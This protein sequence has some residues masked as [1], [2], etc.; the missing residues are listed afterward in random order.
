MLRPDNETGKVQTI[1]S[2]EVFGIIRSLQPF[3][4]VGSKRD[5]IVVGSDSGKIVILQ[6]DGEK[7]VFK[8]IH[9][10]TFGRSGCRRI[11]PGEY[12][13]VDPKGRAIMIGAVEK[14]KFVYVL[15]RDKD[16]NLVI[17]SPLEA[18]KANTVVHS[19]VG[20]DVGFESPIFAAIEIDY[21]EVAQEEKD[22]EMK[23]DHAARRYTKYLTYYEL[24]LGLNHV[25]RKWAEEIDPTSNSLISVP[26][27]DEGP[28]G[29]IICAENCVMYKNQDHAF[30]RAPLPRRLGYLQ[31]SLMIVST[32]T[33]KQKGMFFFLAQSEVGDLYKITLTYDQDE[34]QNVHIRYFDTTPTAL[35]MVILKTGFLFCASEFGNHYLMQFKNIEGNELIETSSL[36]V[37]DVCFKPDP[38]TNL[39]LIDEMESVCPVLDMKV[40][41]LVNEGSPQIYAACG[42]GSRS[43]LRILRHGLSIS[44]A[45]ETEL[46][47]VPNAIWA[48]KR[49]AS[50]P[51]HDYI[52][53]SFV[54][55]TLVLR[56][57]D[58]VEEINDS[59]VQADTQTLSMST[60]GEDSLL[61][62]TPRA[63]RLIRADTRT[64][65]WKAPENH[66]IAQCSVNGQQ[67]AVSLDGGELI[68]FELNQVGMLGEVKRITLPNDITSL[69]LAPVPANRAKASFLAVSSFD[70]SVRIYSLSP[71]EMLEQKTM[72]MVTA[73][74]TSV[75]LENLSSSGSQGDVDNMYLFVGLQ[76]GVLMRS[77]FD[78]TSAQLGDTRPKFLG[79]KPVK[80]VSIVSEGQ[81]AVLALSKRPWLT[82]SHRGG[83]MITPFSYDELESASAFLSDICPEGL[84]CT[85]GN[86]LK[87]ATVDRLGEVFNQTSVPL[88]Y[89][90]RKVLV[91]PVTNHIITL[92]TDC[93][94]YNQAGA[95]ELENTLHAADDVSG[96]NG[97]KKSKM[98]TEN[99]EEED[100]EEEE[101]DPELLKSFVSPPQPGTNFW[102]SCIRVLDPSTGETLFVTELDNNEAAF[103]MS[104]VTFP[105]KGEDVYLAVGTIKDFQLSPQKWSACYIRLYRV[106]G[107]THL[108]LEHKT[109]VDAP[110]LAMCPFHRRLLVGVGNALRLYDM[111]K[112]K[113]LQKCE[114]RNFPAT[115]RSIQVK[116]ERIYVGDVTSGFHYVKYKKAEKR[117][118]IYADS[119]VPRYLTSSAVLDYDTVVGADKFGNVWLNRFPP[120]ASEDAIHSAVNTTFG[121]TIVSGAPNKL[122]DIANFYVGETVT[123]LQKASLVQGGQEVIVYSTLLGGIGVLC[124]FNSREDV[125]FFSHLEM[126]MRQENP[127]LCG[128]DHLAFRSYYFPVK[129]VLD[130]DLCSQ[131]TSLDFAVQKSI[132]EELVSDPLEV[133]KKIDLLKSHIM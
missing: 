118:H 20:V 89:T 109:E 87:I 11:V 17:S 81:K 98:E 112:V 54:N 67:V 58:T 51:Y 46:P 122:D 2:T 83:L 124:P 71:D 15:N 23:G 28:G 76:T 129:D 52:V 13:A 123:S 90:P 85:S 74:P 64:E 5:Y 29:V 91:N 39:A 80:L 14:Q 75:M 9:E 117:F 93:N 30:I 99:D 97:R 34:V 111:G 43:S 3:R 38:L 45:A 105:D 103:S 131:Y 24:D 94:A 119:V 82:Y 62:V 107:S 121:N 110:V 125:D 7:N 77:R 26:G 102:A 133:Q 16:T 101:V 116:S 115:I 92:E 22:V 56:I 48:V 114:N 132:A 61:Q 84:V 12:L 21:D 73:V 19:I 35:S 8:R 60:I 104:L 113:M 31:D 49:T 55:A 69:G 50:Q 6:Y 40:V 44:E 130:G 53:I 96:H 95:K 78:S 33:H 27:G 79:A 72:Q 70:R 106:K 88:S 108:D 47:G 127:P 25:T 41:D 37:E 57:G 36:T 4:F 68:Y 66:S 126:F 65:E 32:A 63:I 100:D 18:H 42:Q 120:D 59:G 86:S 1:L 10:E 128:R